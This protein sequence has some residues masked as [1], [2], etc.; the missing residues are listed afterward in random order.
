MHR[1]VKERSADVETNTV[2]R[3]SACRDLPR[4]HPGLDALSVGEA[5][6]KVFKEDVERCDDTSKIT[7][8]EINTAAKKKAELESLRT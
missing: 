8:F 4:V 5:E 3:C 2:R 6:A 7:D 1:G